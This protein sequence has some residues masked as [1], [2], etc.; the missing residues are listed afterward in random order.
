MPLKLTADSIT[1]DEDE[2]RYQLVIVSDELGT[3]RVDVHRVAL[4]LEEQVRRELRPYALEAEHALASYHA[5]IDGLDDGY[6][7]TDPKSN[8]YRERMVG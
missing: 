3:I 7:P 2:G 1:V 6:E 5:D 8:G 4:E